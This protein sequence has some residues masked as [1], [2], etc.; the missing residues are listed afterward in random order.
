MERLRLW[1]RVW[2][3]IDEE[4]QEVS[5]FADYVGKQVKRIEA[6]EKEVARLQV[7]RYIP[8]ST[9]EEPK[10]KV[11]RAQTFKQYQDIVEQEQEELI[12]KELNAV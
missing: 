4:H 2:L 1:W 10:P 8:P 7:E 12:R 3:G 5:D 9:P 6:L 11:I